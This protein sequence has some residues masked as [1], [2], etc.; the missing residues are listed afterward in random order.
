M[1]P[2]LGIA[3]HQGT[4]CDYVL[5]DFAGAEVEGLSQLLRSAFTPFSPLCDFGIPYCILYFACWLGL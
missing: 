4:T 1:S 3:Q 5:M 2:M